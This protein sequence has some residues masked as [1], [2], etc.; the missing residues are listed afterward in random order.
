ML[1]DFQYIQGRMSK[2][3]DYLFRDIGY[4]DHMEMGY[5]DLIRWGL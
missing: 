5:M 3:L 1:E 4:L 2:L